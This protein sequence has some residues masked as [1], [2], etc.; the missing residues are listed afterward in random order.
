MQT[1]LE[2][3]EE[4]YLHT[5]EIALNEKAMGFSIQVQAHSEQEAFDK[6]KDYMIE[7]IHQNVTDSPILV[8]FHPAGITI[9]MIEILD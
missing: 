2:Q 8:W 6:I 3:I 9:D 5:F 4:N 7:A 1:V